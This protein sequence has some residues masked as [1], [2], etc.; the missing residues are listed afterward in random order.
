MKIKTTMKYRY[1][2]IRI[3]KIKIVITQNVIKDAQSQVAHMLLVIMQ[4]SKVTLENILLVAYKSEHV[5]HKHECGFL[6]CIAR[7]G[8]AELSVCVC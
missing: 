5:F 3:C 4:I 1:I 2:H 8:T 6:L 7:N